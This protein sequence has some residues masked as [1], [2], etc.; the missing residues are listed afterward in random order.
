MKLDSW[1][2]WGREVAAAVRRTKC[3]MGVIVETFRMSGQEGEGPVPAPV[4]EL[5]TQ[6]DAARRI[7]REPLT[8]FAAPEYLSPAGGVAGMSAGAGY[9][10]RVGVA[11]P[12]HLLSNWNLPDR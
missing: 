12:P 3:R 10:G 5:M 6:M 7:T 9:A 11:F 2:G 1:A 8:A 4:E